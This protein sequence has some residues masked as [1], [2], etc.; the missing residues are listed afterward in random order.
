VARPKKKYA[1][2]WHE[3]I[4]GPSDEFPSHG[5]GL[6]IKGPPRVKRKHARK[7]AELGRRAQLPARIPDPDKEGATKP[8]PDYLPSEKATE[9][10]LV[11]LLEIGFRWNWEDGAGN[12]LPQPCDDPS[13]FE[14]ISSEELDFIIE[15]IRDGTKI[16][17]PKPVAS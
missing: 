13:V 14:E 16:P 10:I 9:Q 15:H 8:N 4:E 1:I 3:G 12:P 6:W 5:D 2:K 17:P 11:V 7:I